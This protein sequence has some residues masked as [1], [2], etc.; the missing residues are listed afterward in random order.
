MKVLAIQVSKE[1]WQTL[2]EIDRLAKHVLMPRH[3]KAATEIICA[4]LSARYS[5]THLREN[6]IR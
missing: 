5:L 3:P 4:V 1:V 2:D 6:D